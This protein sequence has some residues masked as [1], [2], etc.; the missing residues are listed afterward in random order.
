M[1]LLEQLHSIV[2]IIPQLEQ[3]HSPGS[4]IPN[5]SSS[6]YSAVLCSIIAA[7]LTRLY[8]DLLELLHSPSMVALYHSYSTH[9]ALLCS[10]VALHSP[11]SVVLHSSC[12]N[13][14]FTR[15]ELHPTRSLSSTTANSRR[16]HLAWEVPQRFSVAMATATGGHWSRSHD[17]MCLTH[18]V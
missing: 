1:A 4:I 8:N 3:L 14:L 9:L 17:K 10:T 5:G 15:P 7:P 18:T 2:S 6:T 12:F 13:S 16:L 11:S